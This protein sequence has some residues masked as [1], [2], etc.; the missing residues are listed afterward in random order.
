MIKSIELPTSQI[1]AL[2]NGATMLMFPLGKIQNK[3]LEDVT[4]NYQ[5]DLEDELLDSSPLQKGDKDVWIK[6]ESKHH[7]QS[8]ATIYKSRYSIDCLDVKFIKVQDIKTKQWANIIP[9]DGIF[10]DYNIKTCLKHTG[11]IYEDND[12]IFLAEVKLN[13]KDTNV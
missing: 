9:N 3:I 12:Y 4:F 10:L 7:Q 6:E 5:E 2:E 11:I 8:G 1:N 13:K